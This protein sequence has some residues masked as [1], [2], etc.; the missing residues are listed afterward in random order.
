MH[1]SLLW[2]CWSIRCRW[3]IACWHCSNYMSILDLTPGFNG[4]G[5]D[6]GKMRWE[7]FNNL[8]Y[9]SKNEIQIMQVHTIT[10]Y[11]LLAGHLCC[12]FEQYSILKQIMYTQ[13][14]LCIAIY[15]SV[16]VCLKHY[17]LRMYKLL[18]H[19]Y[20]YIYQQMALKHTTQQNRKTRG[21]IVLNTPICVYHNSRLVHCWSN[22]HN[23]ELVIVNFMKWKKKQWTYILVTHY[24]GVIWVSLNLKSPATHLFIQQ[25]V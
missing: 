22:E 23:I 24:S 8:R 18:M 5:K 3:S 12:F 2:N 7:T 1:L 25:H 4:L 14:H 20:I 16:S 19:I 9:L 17:V 11:K 13:T 6:N 10:Q 15:N 21:T